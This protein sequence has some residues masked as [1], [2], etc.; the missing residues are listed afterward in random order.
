MGVVRAWLRALAA[1]GI[2]RRLVLLE[3]R[4][5]EPIPDTPLPAGVEVRAL[6][7]ADADAY[8]AFRPEQGA[9]ELGRRLSE[10]QWCFAAWHGGRIISAAWGT[11]DRAWIDYLD[12]ALILGPAEAY[13]YDLYTDPA[14]RRAGLTAPTRIP[15]LRDMR[16]RGYR[17]VLATLLPE[18]IPAWGTPRSVGYRS[19]GWMGYVGLGPWRHHFCRME[20][21]GAR[22]A[23]LEP[24]RG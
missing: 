23:S 24:R 20:P 13:S 15:H 7:P 4:L 3:R 21:G 14:Y 22:P 5:D 1:L 2:Y 17:R 9:A 6:G 18:N 12:R 8:A 19:I 16:D 11:R 10:G